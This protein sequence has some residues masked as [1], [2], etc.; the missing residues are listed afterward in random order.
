MRITDIVQTFNDIV[1]ADGA[2]FLFDFPQGINKD[3]MQDYENGLFVLVP[4]ESIALPKISS[5]RQTF[6]MSGYCLTTFYEAEKKEGTTQQQ[7]WEEMEL[8]AIKI[9]NDVSEFREDNFGGDLQILSAKIVYNHEAF[10]D[11]LYG[12]N[13]EMEIWVKTD[14]DWK[15]PT[16]PITFTVIDGLNPNSPIT[17]VGNN[18]YTCLVAPAD[19][20]VDFTVDN[21]TPDSGEEVQFSGTST[22]EVPTKWF[23]DF[24]DGSDPVEGQ[25]P[26][27]TYNSFGKFTV[28]LSATND[29]SG[30]GEEKE[31][32]MDVQEGFVPWDT[33]E[34]SFWLQ[35]NL[36][37]TVDGSNF[38]SQW[39]DQS[40]NAEIFIQVTASLQLLKVDSVLNG[41][42]IIKKD[43]PTTNADKIYMLGKAPFADA[44]S[45][46]FSTFFVTRLNSGGN[47]IQLMSCDRLINNTL[48]NSGFLFNHSGTQFDL[49]IYTSAGYVTHSWAYAETANFHIFE[50]ASDGA[51]DG[52]CTFSLYI[53]G[54][55]Q[56]DKVNQLKMNT[57]YASPPDTQIMGSGISSTNTHENATTGYVGKILT[58][59]ERTSIMDYLNLKYFP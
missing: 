14:C 4:P 47:N 33:A 2:S 16:P 9:I 31:D 34:T 22:G 57:D 18:P 13:I 5:P 11:S 56:V 28:L 51:A 59:G 39:D 41:L 52:S 36:D 35:S 21:D 27:H 1:V 23:W 55:K 42:P 43:A 24:G 25:S 26:K 45:A 58:A 50:I 7:K 19:M 54:V 49:F 10:N 12:V 37:T 40:V 15:S 8:L 3:R 30:D 48:R 46:A 20:V 32:F 6:K 44:G 53:D 29:T 17:V 38:L